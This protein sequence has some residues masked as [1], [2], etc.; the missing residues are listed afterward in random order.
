[1]KGTFPRQTPS[2]H[3]YSC[4]L[5]QATP[6]LSFPRQITSGNRIRQ[7]IVRFG[8][9]RTHL[10]SP[11]RPSLPKVTW[12]GGLSCM[13]GPVGTLDARL[14]LRSRETGK[15]FENRMH[16]ARSCFEHT[17]AIPDRLDHKARIQPAGRR[18]S[19]ETHPGRSSVQAAAGRFDPVHRR[20]RRSLRPGWDHP[21]YYKRRFLDKRRAAWSRPRP[22]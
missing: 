7:R 12:I 22:G 13:V 9:F 18:C 14:T 21:T 4:D 19:R 3:R 11:P 16:S 1:M 10:R 5:R 17:A 20:R 2:R 15:A 6:F 8:P